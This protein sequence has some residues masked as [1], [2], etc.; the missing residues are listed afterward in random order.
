[1]W[2]HWLIFSVL[3]VFIPIA[4]AYAKRQIC[5]GKSLTVN[6]K[7]T[8]SK[9]MVHYILLMWMYDLFYMA[10]FNNWRWL[11]FAI[12][13]LLTIIVFVN[14]AKAFLSDQ[15]SFQAFLSVELL[16][17]LGI[18]VYLIYLIKDGTLQTIV[19]TIAAALLGGLI[20]LLGVAWSIKN[21]R[22]ERK[23]SEKKLERSAFAP[24]VYAVELGLFEEITEEQAWFGEHDRTTE[25]NSCIG[26]IRNMDNGVLLLKEIRFNDKSYPIYKGGLVEKNKLV[27]IYIAEKLEIKE[28]DYFI[29]SGEDVL[30]NY[31]SYFFNIN[32]EKKKI[33][34]VKKIV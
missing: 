28:N 14:L 16:I 23:E 8:I 9:N 29:L 32:N 22:K 31:V 3:A 12:G 30:G 27:C 1:M 18:A 20:T 24:I 11:I 34:N 25:P 4:F 15:K 7:K 33:D 26:A 19:L 2:Y 10:I 17:G 6:E 5:K 13:I 21:E